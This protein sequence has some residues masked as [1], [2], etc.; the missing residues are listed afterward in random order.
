MALISLAE[1][2][3]VVSRKPVEYPEELGVREEAV[4]GQLLGRV[5]LDDVFQAPL[6]ITPLR[7]QEVAPTALAMPQLAGA[8]SLQP[9]ARP[10]VRF[11]FHPCHLRLSFFR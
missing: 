5:D 9:F 7:R 11:E 10:A 2:V 4:D 6:S 3:G 8:R 1:D